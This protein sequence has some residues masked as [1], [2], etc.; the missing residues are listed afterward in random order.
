[1]NISTFLNITP[2]SII[3]RCKASLVLTGALLLTLNG[4]GGSGVEPRSAAAPPSPPAPAEPVSLPPAYPNTIRV[5]RDF[6][7][8]MDDLTLERIADDLVAEISRHKGKVVGIEVIRFAD[9]GHS[10]WQA[11]P[12]RFIWGAPPDIKEFQPNDETAPPDAKMFKDARTEYRQ[13]QERRYNEQKGRILHEY[14]TRLDEQL[15]RFKEYLLQHPSIQAPCTQFS[16]L[17]ARM[18][19]EDLPYNLTITDGWADC[20]DE[21]D[22]KISGVDVRGKHV[23]IQ[24]VRHTDSQANDAE[25]PQREAFLRTLFP[26]AEVFQPFTLGKAVDS[27]LR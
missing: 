26:S 3:T 2:N 24:L 18:K 11:V 16:S 5:W 15:K 9:A 7:V 22:G 4:C 13:E 14:D 27:L 12:E 23:I 1:M 6:S 20:P 19:K 25:I 10:I 21:R 8:S 17:A